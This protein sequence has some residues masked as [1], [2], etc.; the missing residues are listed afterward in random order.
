M[1]ALLDRLYDFFSCNEKLTENTF[2]YVI[3]NKH[4]SCLISELP[5]YY[6]LIGAYDVSRSTSR[7]ENLISALFF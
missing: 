3:A 5:D 7:S 6:Y 1:I 2:V 4:Q